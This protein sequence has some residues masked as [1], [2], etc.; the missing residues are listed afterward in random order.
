MLDEEELVRLL[1]MIIGSILIMEKIPESARN[2]FQLL[3][4]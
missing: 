1:F 2:I 4:Y 3:P